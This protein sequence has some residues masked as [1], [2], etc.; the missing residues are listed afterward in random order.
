MAEGSP[1]KHKGNGKRRKFY[2]AKKGKNTV[3]KNMSNLNKL[4]LLS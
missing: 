4:F 1:L 2:K 3:S